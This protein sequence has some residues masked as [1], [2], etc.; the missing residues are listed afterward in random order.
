MRGT[1]FRDRPMLYLSVPPAADFGFLFLGGMHQA[2]HIAPVA[3]E[4]AGRMNVQVTAYVPAADESALRAMFWHL[5]PLLA[6]EVK[7]RPMELPG[8]A[9]AAVRLAGGRLAKPALIAAWR[10]RLLRHDALVAAERT[11]TILKRWPGARPRMIHIPHGSGDRAIGFESRI[12]L[13]DHVFVSGESQRARMIDEGLAPPERIAA[14]GSIKLAAVLARPAQSVDL[15]AD[16]KPVV[17]Y[18]PHFETSLSSWPAA[19]AIA[20]AILAS[21]RYNLIVAPHVRLSERIDAAE[22]AYWEALGRRADV[23]FDLDSPRLGDATYTRAADIYLGDVSSQIYEFLATPRPAVFVDLNATAWRDDPN[24]QMWH[25]GEVVPDAAH[26]VSA[27]DRAG[28]RH[29]EFADVQ[30]EL[31]GAALGPTDAGVAGR[32]AD[33]LLS[34]L[35][36]QRAR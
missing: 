5:D 35:R 12:R 36:P 34:V 9:A 23:H 27:L 33:A 18:N 30:R 19:R 17:L 7:V 28:T 8:W 1:E 31:V 29:A 26:V 16:A 10:K 32:T 11:S 2:L 25:F 13:F 6:H 21:G 4:L 22:R 20:E 24:Y 3:L 15:F 14:V